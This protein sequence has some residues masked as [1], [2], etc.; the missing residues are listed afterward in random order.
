MLTGKCNE[1]FQKWFYNNWG[2]YPGNISQL[3]LEDDVLK[4][5]SLF[6]GYTVNT[7][8]KL[9]KAVADYNQNH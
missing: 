6:F 1:D 2:R 9:K 5:T 7:V 8:A 3:W 4:C